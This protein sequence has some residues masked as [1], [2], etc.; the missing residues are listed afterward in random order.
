MNPH[1]S[2]KRFWK[3][4]DWRA[5]SY[6]TAKLIEDTTGD[7]DWAVRMADRLGAVNI[8]LP[9]QWKGIVW[10]RRN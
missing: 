3:R 4:A 10:A 6:A 2:Y 7:A 1:L 5:Y 8:C 9:D